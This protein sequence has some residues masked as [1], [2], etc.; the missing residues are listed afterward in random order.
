MN[1]VAERQR[2]WD[3]LLLGGPSGVGK[4]SAG[5]PL[6]RRFD[7]GITEV[8]DLH[9]AV[10]R[11]TTPAQQPTLHFWRTNPQA[12]QFDPERILELHISVCRVLTPVIQAVVD[13]HVET[14]TP[15][16]LEGD[17]LLPE[18]PKTERVKSVFLYEPD[19]AQIVRNF[20]A[21]EPREP[22]QTKRARVSWLHGQWLADEC[23]RLGLVAL[24]ARPW[25]TLL[26]RIA[27]AT[28]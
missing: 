21:R 13:N 23:R 12:A 5:Y 22:E 4:S 3:V 14:R 15:I 8:D 18:Q 7:V 20:A 25:T 16:V 10:E 19:E 11:L 26:D 2:T 28:R 27:A 9:I 6:A 17:Y 24:P 1:D